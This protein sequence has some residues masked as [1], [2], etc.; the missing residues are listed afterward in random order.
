MASR[1][2]HLVRS[3]SLFVNGSGV[4]GRLFSR[5]MVRILDQLHEKL[6]VGGIEAT[7]PDGSERRI[8]FHKAGPVAAKTPK[9]ASD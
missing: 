1:G 4:L 7:L 5:G 3:G 9:V 6:A 2:A 8:G